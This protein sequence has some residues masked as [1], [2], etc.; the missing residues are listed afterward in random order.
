MATL[1][2]EIK[3]ARIER[4]WHQQ[5]LKEVTGISQTYLSQI[6]LD[7]VD[8][9]FSIVRRIAKALGLSLDRCV[10]EDTDG[11]GS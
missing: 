6:G 11:Q 7:K 10:D 1:G 5:Y 4:G 2:K 8:P 3:K 9:R